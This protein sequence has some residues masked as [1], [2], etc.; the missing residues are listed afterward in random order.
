[1]RPTITRRGL[2]ASTAATTLTAR[3]ARA[4]DKT[5]RIGVLTDM[6]GTYSA[7]LGPGSVLGAQLAV[8]D[9]QKAHPDIAVE[10]ISADLLLKPDVALSIAG[11][12]FDNKGVDLL[13]DVPLSSAAYA[14]GD[15]VKT[16]DKL[17]IFT[18]AASSQ[19]TGE[20]CGPNHLHW[21]YDTWGIPHAIVAATIQDGGDSW[22]F[23]TADYAFGHA[24]A[25]DCMNFVRKGG[26]KVL[27]EAAHPFPGTTDFSAFL[28]QAKASGAKVI[29]LANG[30]TDSVNCIKQAVEFGLVKGGQKVVGTGLLMT[31]I[32]SIGL[33]AAQGVR[34]AEPFYWDTNDATRAF[35]RRFAARMTT[36]AMPNSAQAGGYSSVGHYLKTVATVGVDRAKGSGRDMIAAMRAHQPD[37]V[38]FG[39]SI[40]REDGRVIHPIHLFEAKTPAESK[41]PWDLLKLV[42]T[43]PTDQAFRPINEGGCKMI[44][45]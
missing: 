21:V 10:L 36:K 12:W 42:A 24:L 31:D 39:Q 7:L 11:D 3:R 29:G 37:D 23:V 40:I 2:I 35:S 26:G 33:E 9:F 15:M 6:G 20:H 4:A 1:M 13:I 16:K 45:V 38:I 17:A 44:K 43:I 25:N 34:L 32:H 22:F 41:D 14:I 8:E 30:G 19:V 5:I 28:L 18:G 27:G